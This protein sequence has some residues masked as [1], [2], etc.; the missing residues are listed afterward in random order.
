MWARGLLGLPRV[1]RV[2]QAWK[3]CQNL[4]GFDRVFLALVQSSVGALPEF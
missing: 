1:L 4:L 3:L 2:A